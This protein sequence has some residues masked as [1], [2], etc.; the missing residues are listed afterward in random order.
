MRRSALLILGLGFMACAAQESGIRTPDEYVAEQERLADEQAKAKAARGDDRM[1]ADEETD[2]EENAKWDQSHAELE[3]KRATRSAQTCPEALPVE[4][5]AKVERGVAKVTLI[6]ANAGHAKTATIDPPYAETPV[7]KCVL[8][9]LSAVIVPAFVGDEHTVSWE[10]DLRKQEPEA[11][12]KGKK[13][14]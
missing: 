14:Q 3:L 11:G 6:F 12:A 4:E 5:Q 13:G 10:V 7:G 8:R 2:T 1:D 9:A